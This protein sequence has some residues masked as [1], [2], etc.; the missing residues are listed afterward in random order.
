MN[1]VKIVLVGFFVLFAW[2]PPAQATPCDECGEQYLRDLTYCDSTRDSC[3]IKAD[4]WYPPLIAAA[5]RVCEAGDLSSGSDAAA[6][7]T[8]YWL[9]Y[10]YEV[11]KESCHSGWNKCE[12]RACAR[13]DACELNCDDFE[14]SYSRI[15]GS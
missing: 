11:A 12:S 3:L 7:S 10:A 14:D 9:I 13:K 6:C 8:Y 1:L 15:F 4:N 2:L 5:Q